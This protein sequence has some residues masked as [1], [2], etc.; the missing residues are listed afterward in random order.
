MILWLISVCPIWRSPGMGTALQVHLTAPRQQGRIPSWTC[1]LKPCLCSPASRA[2]FAAG[3]Y[4]C[5]MANLVS[6]RLQT[7]FRRAASDQSA[8][9]CLTAR[10]HLSQGPGF[11]FKFGEPCKVLVC[12]FLQPVQD[13]IHWP[14][15]P[16]WYQMNLQGTHY[17]LSPWSPVKIVKIIS[18][19]NNSQVNIIC[20]TC[21]Q[22]DWLH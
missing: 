10:L 20:K 2:C 14:F 7:L 5:L 22:V 1:W 21:S 13:R 6:L 19:S 17:D 8:P 11:A 4:C 12:P 18:P 16:T 9:P 3:G 15:L